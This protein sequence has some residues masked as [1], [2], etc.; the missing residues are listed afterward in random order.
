M[1]QPQDLLWWPGVCPM[2]GIHPSPPVPLCTPGEG[3]GA[4]GAVG[5]LT[6]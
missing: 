4:Q 5:S 3:K 2:E 6:R 1:G